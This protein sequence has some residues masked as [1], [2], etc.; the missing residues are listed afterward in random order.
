MASPVRVANVG[1]PK[2]L[3]SWYIK[4][5]RGVGQPGRKYWESDLCPVWFW[6]FSELRETRRNLEGAS[7]LG[8][9]TR[10]HTLATFRACFLTQAPAGC[11]TCFLG[12]SNGTL[13]DGCDDP[14]LYQPEGWLWSA[15]HLGESGQAG[16]GNQGHVIAAPVPF[17]LLGLSYCV[18]VCPFLTAQ[19]GMA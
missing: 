7:S 1:W 2:I 19:H 14:P 3:V 8:R 12:S 9:Q 17:A 6:T 18:D 15:K 4:T 5:Q 16:F 11:F 13:Q 10:S